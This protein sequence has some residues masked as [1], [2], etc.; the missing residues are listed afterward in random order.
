MFE[1]TID[2]ELCK[3]DGLCAM[4]CPVAVLQQD[5]K[6]TIPKISSE[7]LAHCFGCGQCVSICPQGAISH[8]HYP[9]GT[10]HPI[11]TDYVPSYD[12]VLEL[13]RSRR[14]KRSFKKKVVGKEVIEKV[15]EVARLGPSGHNEQ[16]TEF[17]VV[18]DEEMIHEIGKL[19][20][21]GLKKLA[22]PFK[23]A[24][25]RLMMRTMIG[26]RGAEY[27][28]ELAPEFEELALMY[29]NGT[30]IILHDPPVLLLFC[31]DSVG[32][33]FAGTNANIALHNAALAAETLGLGCFYCGFVVTVSER[34]DSI[35]RLVGLPETHKIYGALAMGYART[36][37]KRW[38]ERNPA[39]VTWLGMN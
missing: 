10:I 25:G 21:A 29:N 14:S 31:A 6:V 26:S 1:I 16:S 22:M 20:A 36:K 23:Y 33:T 13:F 37:F 35:A 38:P 7:N 27:I 18:Q 39:K 3:K 9:E 19:T 24:I 32:G 17:V 30:D 8:S 28:G 5:E 11:R 2:T 34:D 15:L 12:Q 4:T